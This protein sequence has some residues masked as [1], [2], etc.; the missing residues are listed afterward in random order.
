[1]QAQMKMLEQS[2][3]ALAVKLGIVSEAGERESNA[4]AY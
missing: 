2:V 1:M 4:K 3:N